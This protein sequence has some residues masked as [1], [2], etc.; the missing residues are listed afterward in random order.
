MP[1]DGL[2]GV[3]V[4]F[5]QGGF[6]RFAGDIDDSTVSIGW[7]GAGGQLVRFV[8]E[9]DLAVAYVTSTLGSRMAMYDPRGL[10]VLAAAVEC[11][12]R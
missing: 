2:M 7:G 3:P 5:T 11:A 1:V 8:P 9:L 4:A 10:A 6:A 12:R